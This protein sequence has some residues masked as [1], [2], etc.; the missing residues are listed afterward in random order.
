MQLLHHS[1]GA[2]LDSLVDTEKSQHKEKT[3]NE[4]VSTVLGHHTLLKKAL[5]E[6]VKLSM[7]LHLTSDWLMA[8]E[9]VTTFIFF[10]DQ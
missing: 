4:C 6:I 2:N 7:T 10:R 3:N 8:A 9:N 1:N 5:A